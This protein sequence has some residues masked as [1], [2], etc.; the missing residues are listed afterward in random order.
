MII[1]YRTIS[2]CGPR[3]KNEDTV[4]YVLLTEQQRAMFILCDGMGRHRSGDIASQTIVNTI[5]NYWRGNPKRR[6]CSKK[7]ADA[8]YV[9]K[10]A[11]EKRPQV[12]YGND[13]NR[14]SYT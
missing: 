6:D 11:L 7:I 10:V 3:Y 2:G 13:R 14:W 12:E 5:C 4:G 9:A 8:C 1:Q